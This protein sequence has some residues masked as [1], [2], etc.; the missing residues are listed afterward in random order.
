MGRL[1]E[2]RRESAGVGVGREAKWGEG[3][4]FSSEVGRS[5]ALWNFPLPCLQ[6]PHSSFSTPI[7]PWFPRVLRMKS[8]CTAHLLCDPVD[9]PWEDMDRQGL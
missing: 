2:G 3:G 4:F 1:E 5:Q 7:P 9:L 6:N 8:L